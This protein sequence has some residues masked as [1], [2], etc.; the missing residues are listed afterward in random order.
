MNTCFLMDTYLCPFTLHISHP[1]LQTQQSQAISILLSSVDGTVLQAEILA[2][3]RIAGPK[4]V[5]LRG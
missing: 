5:L 1:L 2:T 4:G 3:D